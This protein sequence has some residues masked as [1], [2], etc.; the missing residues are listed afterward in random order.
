[1]MNFSL[2]G[3]KRVAGP[4]PAQILLLK[5]RQQLQMQ[6]LA[7]NNMHHSYNKSISQ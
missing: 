4:S 5:Q 6:L 1:M 2:H 3:K 7:K